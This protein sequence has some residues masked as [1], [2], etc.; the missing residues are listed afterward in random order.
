MYGLGLTELGW[1]E[2]M[3]VCVCVCF[4]SSKSGSLPHATDHQLHSVPSAQC[5]ISFLQRQVKMRGIEQFPL[6]AWGARLCYG[7][8]VHRYRGV[9]GCADALWVGD[10][11]CIA[12]LGMYLA[13]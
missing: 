9:Q 7:F 5:P 6:P 13:L 2:Q 4:L 1:A 3:C 11:C 10:A 12:R 8:Y